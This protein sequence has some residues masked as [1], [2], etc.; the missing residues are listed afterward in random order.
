MQFYM[1]LFL[2]LAFLEGAESRFAG[3]VLVLG[4]WYRDIIVL[5]SG[6]PMP[7]RVFGIAL[8]AAAA[9]EYFGAAGKGKGKKA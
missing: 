9:Y 4:Q 1:A 6:P 5:D 8:A 7:V 3:M 2:A